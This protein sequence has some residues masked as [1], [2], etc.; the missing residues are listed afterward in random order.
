MR[1]LV[2]EEPSSAESATTRS[3]S[4]RNDAAAATVRAAEPSVVTTTMSP[5]DGAVGGE[6]NAAKLMRPVTGDA[7]TLRANRY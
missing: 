2:D 6:P 3:P 1:A 4:T 7:S 5:A